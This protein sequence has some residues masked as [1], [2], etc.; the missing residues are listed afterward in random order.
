MANIL[1][2]MPKIRKSDK[3]GKSVIKYI[4]IDSDGF[5]SGEYD[6]KVDAFVKHFE[7]PGSKVY[8]F[9]IYELIS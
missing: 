7:T 9:M 2:H 3:Y 6:C 1:K 8:K 4:V 5:N